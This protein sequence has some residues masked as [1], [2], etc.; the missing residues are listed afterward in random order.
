MMAVCQEILRNISMINDKIASIDKRLTKIELHILRKVDLKDFEI[1][2]IKDLKELKQFL[3][4]VNDD[5]EF[6][7]KL[8]YFLYLNC[9]NGKAKFYYNGVVKKI[10]KLVFSEE[11]LN[12][13]GWSTEKSSAS[14]SSQD[15]RIL[16]CQFK[17]FQSICL[18]VL[19]Y[20]NPNPPYILDDVAAGLKE[21][22]KRL[23]RY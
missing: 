18:D 20:H 10:L 8:I 2:V 1:S 16:L 9:T 6:R 22:F 19:N 23:V 3:K 5:G 17:N 11:F 21:F 7:Q 4:T 15:H 13:L 14:T 12:V